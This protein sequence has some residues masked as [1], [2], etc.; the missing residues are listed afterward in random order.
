M[1]AFRSWLLLLLLLLFDRGWRN[2]GGTGCW[3]K[4][5]GI[6]LFGKE[7][8]FV[9]DTSRGSDQCVISGMH[10]IDH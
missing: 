1:R 2:L 3:I 6:H 5:T 10:S 9:S 4:E 8:Y 7:A